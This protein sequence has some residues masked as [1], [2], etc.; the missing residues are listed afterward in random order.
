MSDETGYTLSD[1]KKIDRAAQ[2]EEVRFLK[3]QQWAVATAGAVLAG[4]FLASISNYHLTSLERFCAVLLTVGGVG[5]GWFFLDDLP[6]GLA[7]VRRELDPT[8]REA[9]TRG[10]PIVN[11]HKLILAASAFVVVWAVLFKVH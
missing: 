11:L 10:S 9:A 2:H 5:A 4:A 6:C 1:Q 8:D 3:K 7:R